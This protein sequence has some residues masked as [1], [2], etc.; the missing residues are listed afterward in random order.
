M[1]L[2]ALPN[3]DIDRL[4]GES[5]NN[6]SSALVDGVEERPGVEATLAKPSHDRTPSLVIGGVMARS[7]IAI[8]ADA[9]DPGVELVVRQIECD[10]LRAPKIGEMDQLKER[11]IPGA[12]WAGIAQARLS[13]LFAI[14]E[15]HARAFPAPLARF[16]GSQSIQPKT[17]S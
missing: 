3:G 5:P 7:S 9:E 15:G 2:G 1:F 14:H 17:T 4:L 13:Q 6:D 16:S 12:G 10:H 8:R 11:I